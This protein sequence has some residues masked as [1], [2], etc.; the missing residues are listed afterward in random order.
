MHVWTFLFRSIG[1][2]EQPNEHGLEEAGWRRWTTASGAAETPGDIGEA[3]NTLS[4]YHRQRAEVFTGRRRMTPFRATKDGYEGA[5]VYR[6]S[7]AGLA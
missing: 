6:P 2:D 7:F 4:L 5:S 3:N 1:H